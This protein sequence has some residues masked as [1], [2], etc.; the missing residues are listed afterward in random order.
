MG[1][2]AL[3]ESQ[4]KV[5]KLRLN[6]AAISKRSIALNKVESLPSV[7]HLAGRISPPMKSSSSKVHIKT[8][9]SQQ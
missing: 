5:N 9:Q 7:R 4:K 2:N 3:I 8:E 1:P 6:E